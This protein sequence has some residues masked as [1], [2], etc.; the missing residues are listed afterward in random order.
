[1]QEFNQN[2]KYLLV[3][4]FLFFTLPIALM[5]LNDNIKQ[6]LTFGYLYALNPIAVFIVSFIYALKCGFD[7]KFPFI[8][9]LLFIPAVIIY[10]E[11]QNIIFAFTYCI[12]SFIGEGCGYWLKK[13]I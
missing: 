9:G 12:F 10:F 7:K 4:V 2:R 6:S 5:F 8:V 11:F 1:M 13:L 3:I